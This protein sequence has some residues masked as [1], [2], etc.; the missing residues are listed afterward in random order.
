MAASLSPDPKRPSAFSL[1]EIRQLQD[2]LNR[3]TLLAL[4]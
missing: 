3:A 1:E 4:R 2:R